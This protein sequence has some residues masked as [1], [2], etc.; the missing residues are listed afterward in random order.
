[1]M[2]AI[3][4]LPTYLGIVKHVELLRRVSA[5]VK[6]DRLLPSWVIWQ[7]LGNVEHLPV[8][9]HP[10]VVLLVVLRDLLWGKQLSSCVLGPED[11]RALVAS[12]AFVEVSSEAA[13]EAR[14]EN[15]GGRRSRGGSRGGGGRGG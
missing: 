14:V 8:N 5:G 1:M 6:Q 13:A 15:E 9:D 10:A 7:E 2:T 4:G 11:E 3:D 12:A